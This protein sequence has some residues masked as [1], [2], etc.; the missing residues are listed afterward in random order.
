M[1]NGKK[2]E[3]FAHVKNP[4]DFF[5]VNVPVLFFDVI[6]FTKKHYKRCNAQMYKEH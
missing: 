3:D 6:G 5:Y 4:R 2:R 1:S